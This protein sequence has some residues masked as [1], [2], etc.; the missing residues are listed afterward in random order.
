MFRSGFTEA[1]SG[2]Q[3]AETARRDWTSAVGVRKAEG[4]TISG[5]FKTGLIV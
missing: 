1:C 2:R 5:Q 4:G 3:E